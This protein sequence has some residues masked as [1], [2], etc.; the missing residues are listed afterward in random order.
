MCEK[1]QNLAAELQAAFG[2]SASVQVLDLGKD[3]PARGA[4]L[5]AIVA[6]IRKAKGADAPKEKRVVSK[7]QEDDVN[8]TIA[9]IMADSAFKDSVEMRDCVA[10][11]M[12]E[13]I[14]GIQELSVEVAAKQ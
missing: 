10:K 13:L 11:L 2:D 5:E 3:T 4:T 12:Y 14:A 1:C 8:A 6:A 7:E 9:E